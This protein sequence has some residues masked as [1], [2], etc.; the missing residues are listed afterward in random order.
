MKKHVS[1][2]C[3]TLFSFFFSLFSFAH[4]CFH[5]PYSAL[6]MFISSEQKERDSA[7]AYSEYH[8]P[9]NKV[10]LQMN[11]LSA[12]TSV[13]SPPVWLNFSHV[14]LHS[15]M[16]VEVLGTVLGTAIQGQIVG[17]ANAPCLPG[18]GELVADPSNSSMS[19]GL[20]ASESVISI[21]HTVNLFISHCVRV[22]T[23]NNCTTLQRWAKFMWLICFLFF[24]PHRKW[25]IW[26][27]P[28]LSA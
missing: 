15:G 20:N 25:L 19:A 1:S 16:T 7:T 8:S 12:A 14:S 17:M 3:W 27:L 18:P 9:Q 13:V 4:Q 28:V 26:S 23:N 10:I 11:L 24:L 22:S 6:T 21:E 2:A 5:V